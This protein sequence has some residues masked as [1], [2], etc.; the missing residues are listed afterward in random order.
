MSRGRSAVTDV[1]V[2]LPTKLFQQ[3]LAVLERRGTTLDDY[4]RLKLKG[5]LR[6][7]KFYSVGDRYEFGKYRDEQVGVVI[8]TDPEYVAWCLREVEGFGLDP[9]ALN[10][11]STMDVDL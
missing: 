4:V 3:A 8:N 9:E 5:L 1:S 7:E 10:Y 2:Q 6:P 11:L